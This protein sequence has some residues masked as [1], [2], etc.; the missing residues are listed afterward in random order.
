VFG[1]NTSD[2]M[3]KLL[4]QLKRLENWTSALICNRNQRS[5]VV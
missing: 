3:V 5:K 1:E 4:Q 2:Y